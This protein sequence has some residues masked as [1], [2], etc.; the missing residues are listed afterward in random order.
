M[1]Q[2]DDDRP[3]LLLFGDGE[4][5]LDALVAALRPRAH[6]SVAGES[7]AL[8]PAV[9]A[10]VP[11]LTVLVGQATETE[12][13]GGLL[14][15]L[16]QHP[17]TEGSPVA[18][19][20]T[21]DS[22]AAKLRASE[23]GMV[24]ILPRG[25][26]ADGMARQMVQLA[27]QL[28]EDPTVTEAGDLAEASVDDLVQIL[29]RELQSG[30][31][32]VSQVDG[33]RAERF[34]VRAGQPMRAAISQFIERV[35]PLIAEAKPLQYAFHEAP[36]T[37]LFTLDDA[38]TASEGSARAALGGRRFLLIANNPAH[39]DALAQELRA[40]DALVVVVSAD[41]SGWD[42]ARDLDPEVA[43]IDEEGLN[44]WGFEAVAKLRS[45]PQLR[46]ASLV[47]M[48]SNELLPSDGPPRI[49]RLAAN[50][51]RLSD[52]EGALRARAA[53]RQEFVARIETV[54]PTRVLRALLTSDGAW[55]VRA[56]PR[57][58]ATVTL[59]LAEGLVAGAS[60]QLGDSPALEGAAAL[61]CLLVAGSGRLRATPAA[62]PAL[63]NMLMPLDE[64]VRAAHA[65]G[66]PLRVTRSPSAPPPA[67]DKRDRSSMGRPRMP[68]PS[69]ET[70]ALVG[71]LEDL[72]GELNSARASSLPPPVP[73][74]APA[75]PKAA[76]AAVRP[77]A[78]RPAGAPPAGRP[79]GATATAHTAIPPTAPPPPRAGGANPTRPLAAPA[80]PASTATGA[81][82]GP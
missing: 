71:E 81:R 70:A 68:L 53:A 5:M 2:L 26:S 72:V 16:R 21:D 49:E 37:P 43:L 74:P 10:N 24:S 40:C 50:I 32:S 36:L 63:A 78:T 55:N 75:A 45:D 41:G 59:A 12:T 23:Y 38:E 77:P 44:H 28:Y 67:M 11:D 19:L 64:A 20:A 13:A 65:E 73:R 47:V 79:R 35:R 18:L 27:E 57:G 76:G 39:A 56:K 51:A 17:L 69:T 6:V 42:R 33:Q 54:G 4:A 30:I 80:R 15:E 1:T 82:S 34:V 48:D 58:G 66:G 14:R 46:W 31:L 8:V 9:L 29:G 25:A 52:S 61:A 7:D 3:T 62:R 60:A 22:L